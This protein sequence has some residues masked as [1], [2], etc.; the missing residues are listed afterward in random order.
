MARFSLGK[1]FAGLLLLSASAAP[2]AV[3]VASSQ[4]AKAGIGYL[5][6]GGGISL[7]RLV[8]RPA[9]PKGTVLLLHGFPETIYA[10]TD[11]ARTLGQDYEVH[12]IDWPGFGLSS[13]PAM[14]RFGYAP[15]DYAR[16]LKD[17]IRKARID[18]SRLTIYATDIGALPALLAALDDPGIARKIIVGDFAPFNRPGYMHERLQRLKSGLAADQARADLNAHRDDTLEN[19]FRRGLPKETQ[20]ELPAD[21]KEDMVRGWSH[22]AMTS[23][24]AF[25]HYYGQ[26]TRD[27]D[28][29]EANIGRLRTPVKVIWGAEDIYISKAMGVELAERTGAELTL[30]PRIGHYPHHQAPDVTIGEIRSSFR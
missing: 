27:E 8:V 19:A 3:P 4:E 21:F 6:I 26:F 16:V 25:Y 2:A 13:R 30:L 22:G 29:L 17:Y 10:W 9:Q 11:L 20:Y 15:R 12:A 5:A 18:R 1:L 23:A 7:R 14:D 28:H 24:D